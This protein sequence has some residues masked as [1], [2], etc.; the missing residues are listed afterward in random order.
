MSHCKTAH[1]TGNMKWTLPIIKT[2]ACDL[3][4]WFCWSGPVKIV[5]TH[6]RVR[7]KNPHTP[8]SWAS[9]WAC[10]S[11]GWGFSQ[12]ASQVWNKSPNDLLFP[13]K[14]APIMMGGNDFIVILPSKVFWIGVD[15]LC[16]FR[17]GEEKR[18]EGGRRWGDTVQ[19]I[20]ISGLCQ[21]DDTA[22]LRQN[23]QTHLRLWCNVHIWTID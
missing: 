21:S 17:A 3:L 6:I 18:R 20:T 4:C 16:G 10:V 22:H 8:H 2:A 7:N 1:V 11:C 15:L 12:T 13:K 23:N 5:K 14:C 19:T 9:F